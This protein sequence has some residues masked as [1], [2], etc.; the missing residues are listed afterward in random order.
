MEAAADEVGDVFHSAPAADVLEVEGG[1]LGVILREAKVGEFGVAVDD[2]LE[3]GLVEP[4]GNFR[5][6]CAEDW[7]I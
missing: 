1:E 3:V 2:G 5:S 4:G 7:I 6:G